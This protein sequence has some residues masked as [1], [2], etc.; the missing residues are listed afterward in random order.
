MPKDDKTTPS[1]GERK[2]LDKKPAIW[3]IMVYLAGDNNLAD[4]CV[5]AL[6]E[7]KAADVDNRIKVVAQFDPTARKVRTRRFVINGN[8]AN[9]KSQTAVLEGKEY[10]YKGRRKIMEDAIEGLPE[11]SVKF[12]P[13]DPPKDP[14]KDPPRAAKADPDGESDSGDP[15]LLFDF[16]SWTVEHHPAQH[17][18]VILSGHGGGPTE[19][20]F[21]RDE[22]SKGTLTI[23]ELGQVF[24]AV[25]SNLEDLNGAP[26]EIDIV[27]MDA[28]LMSMAEVC[29]QFQSSV[30][31]MVSSES[32]GPQS[33]WPYGHIL[34]GLKQ[35]LDQSKG[36][37]SPED[38]ASIVLDEHVDFYME[39]AMTNGL[40]VDISLMDVHRAED[41]AGVLKKLSETLINELEADPMDHPSHFRDQIILA[42]WEAQ[43]Y[44][45]ELFV[46]L[47]DF[48]DCLQ[49]RYHPER[50]MPVPDDDPRAEQVKEDIRRRITVYEHC[51]N[52][53]N[54]IQSRLVRKSCYMGATF[55]YSFGVSIYFPWSEVAPDYNS[56]ELT[57]VNASDWR[58]FLEVY[59][60]QTRR[61]PRGPVVTIEG[62]PGPVFVENIR[63]T[64]L[65]DRGPV[66]V[67]IRSMRNPPVE[68][69]VSDCTRVRLEMVTK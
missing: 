58:K 13:Q 57:F 27:G 59:V 41:L 19:Q 39:Y 43:S 4:E 8:A 28:C 20:E 64:P 45:G 53:K 2:D 42:H 14:S 56:E 50:A 17:Y 61:S 44:N 10:R 36:D 55:Q 26:L 6:T 29:H 16:I 1:E 11:G 51:E 35:H 52:V 31:Y 63:K 22:S 49:K 54:L 68:P 67:I 5:Y 65:D 7:M 24:Q 9:P 23:K 47:Y 12:P 40:S 33:G 46:D 34:Q 48:C 3:T 62:V 60:R 21:L 15:K 30:R 32:F 66:S 25:R 37:T 38:L 18:M 69:S